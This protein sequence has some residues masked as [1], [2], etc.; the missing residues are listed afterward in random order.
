MTTTPATAAMIDRLVR[1]RVIPTLRAADAAQADA[2]A[3]DVVAGGI[4]V[5][6]FTATTPGWQDVVAA[7]AAK[8]TATVGLGTVTSGEVAEQAIAAG[9]QFLV[10]P[11]AVPDARAVATRADVLFIEGGQTPNEVWAASRHGLAKLFPASVGGL[12]YL[13]S[14][15]AV[16]PD[17]LIT[18]TGGVTVDNAATW[19]RAGAAA[20]SIGSDL[21]A[22]P[23][24]VAA[25]RALVASV[26]DTP[27]P[28]PLA[29]A[30]GAGR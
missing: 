4:D 23:D 3:A 8:G 9:A 5:I 14:L 1:G 20:V 16:L 18:A 28:A 27:L 17:A 2:W 22:Q 10:S 12:G 6:E 26:A 13:K 7:W 30:A 29:T 15:R 21:F 19:L 24:L 25:S 11:F